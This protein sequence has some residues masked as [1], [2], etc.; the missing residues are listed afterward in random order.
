MILAVTVRVCVAF[1][2]LHP[3]PSS[4]AA[5]NTWYKKARVVF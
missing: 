4:H 2:A 3:C 1:S 5:L